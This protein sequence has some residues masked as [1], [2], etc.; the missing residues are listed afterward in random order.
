MTDISPLGVTINAPTMTYLKPSPDGTMV[1]VTLP[2]IVP[3]PPLQGVTDADLIG[4]LQ[5]RLQVREYLQSSTDA[6]VAKVAAQAASSAAIPPAT[7]VAAQTRASILK[8][9]AET[10][11]KYAGGHEF[12][13]DLVSQIVAMPD[14]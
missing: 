8:M 12:A 4:E 10:R 3:D 13:R 7:Q 2:S 9:I 11:T 6:L 5:R 14:F 1:P